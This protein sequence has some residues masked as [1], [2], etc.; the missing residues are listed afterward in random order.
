MG[1][2]IDSFV[3]LSRGHIRW[4]ALHGRCICGCSLSLLPVNH[5]E[6][7]DR[8]PRRFRC[9][10]YIVNERGNGILGQWLAS[11][12]YFFSIDRPMRSNPD[13]LSADIKRI[14]LVLLPVMQKTSVL[15]R[16]KNFNFFLNLLSGRFS[17]L[18]PSI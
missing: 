13:I 1:Y 17:F 10:R 5:R 8:I 3:P 7:G 18:K 4:R 16:R 9:L 15:N 2:I 12:L 6:T 14:N 11:L